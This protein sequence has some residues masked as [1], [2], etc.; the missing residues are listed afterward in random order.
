MTVRFFSFFFC[1]N[2][3]VCPLGYTQDEPAEE[4]APYKLEVIIF[5]RTYLEPYADAEHWR[6]DLTLA[7][8]TNVAHLKRFEDGAA[9]NDNKP[10]TLSSPQL[11]T[12]PA[13]QRD[14]KKTAAAIER[15]S[16]M[17][18]LFH[19][20]WI[21]NLENNENAPAILINRGQIFNNLHELN[22]WIKISIARY[23]HIQTDLW[24]ANYIP[25]TGE[26][27][28]FWP[29]IPPIPE[30]F[31]SF[32]TTEKNN[33]QIL[34]E[35]NAFEEPQERISPQFFDF[36]VQQPYQVETIYTLQQKRRMRSGEL[37][38]LDHPKLGLLIMLKAVEE[39]SL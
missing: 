37:H 39:A 7:Y 34:E 18:V 16:N 38:Y 30:V 1:L 26:L 17:S 10:E 20:T 29:S 14:L 35:T 24:L 11:F 13:E 28:K 8:P 6:K 22:G 21:Q 2:I 15:H 19:E 4:L 5:K 32:N 31:D 23:L 12:L 27:L 3:L 25:N 33:E 9:P 36:A